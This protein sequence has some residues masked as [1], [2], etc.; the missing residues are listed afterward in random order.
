MERIAS[1]T[2]QAKID[3]L[4]NNGGAMTKAG[5][6]FSAAGVTVKPGQSFAE[7]QSELVKK[8]AT[9]PSSQANTPTTAK[10]GS[11]AV[12]VNGRSFNFPSQQAADAFKAAAAK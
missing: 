9:K 2:D 6:E 8:H 10:S 3:W 12:T 4:S 1:D 11:V 5:G 7:V